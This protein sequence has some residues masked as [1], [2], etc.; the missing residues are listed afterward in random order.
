MTRSWI[1]WLGCLLPGVAI[2]AQCHAQSV[3]GYHGGPDRRGNF[4]VPTL[5]WERA[6]S[7]H[8]D[9][10]FHP[11][12]A[13]PL[14]AQPLYWQPPG[15]AS[16]MRIVA[17]ENDDV[18]AIDAKSG[19]QIWTRSLGRPIA[20]S[21]QPCGNIDPLGITGTPVV[22][23]AMQA[24][25]ID[26]M[27]GDATG[28]H[29]RVFALSLKDGSTLPGWPVE[30][31]EALAARGQHFNTRFQNQRGALAVFEGRVY[32]PYGG[33]FGDCGDYRGW[34]LGIRLQDPRDVVGWSTRGRGGGIW[35]PGGISSDGR[36]LFVATGNTLGASTWSDGEANGGSRSS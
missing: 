34:V 23:A 12:F 18:H 15:S 11:R 35:A 17:T 29:H 36:A 21:T 4:V 26:A 20:L 7:V 5:T 10:G 31:A 28:A 3:L 16:G 13:G 25:F 6:A 2:A 8:L 32:V 30:V 24:V 22:D 1:W 33:H 27:V 19:S 9:A 14:Y